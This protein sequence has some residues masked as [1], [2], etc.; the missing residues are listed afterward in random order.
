MPAQYMVS[1]MLVI[2]FG[3]KCVRISF[4]DSHALVCFLKEDRLGVVPTTRIK[5]RTK[6]IDIGT[7]CSVLWSDKKLY[8]ATLIFTGESIV[9]VN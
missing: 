6:N 3:F 2:R 7:I 1:S 5:N 4:I 9:T 8:E